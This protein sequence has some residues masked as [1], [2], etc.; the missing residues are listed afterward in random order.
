MSM[1]GMKALAQ[2]AVACK[3]W[4]WMR[5]ASDTEG[6]VFM[7]EHSGALWFVDSRGLNVHRGGR[8]CIPDLTDPATLGCLLALVREA[9]GDWCDMYAKPSYDYGGWECGDWFGDTEAHA[10]VAALEAAP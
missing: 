5:G 7:A 3:G 8:E 9:H 6:R 10:L 1:D 4:R 2:R